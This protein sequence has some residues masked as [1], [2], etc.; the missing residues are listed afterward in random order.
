MHHSIE[1]WFAI[2]PFRYRADTTLNNN[3]GTI[4]LSIFCEL[5]LHP[6]YAGR[7]VPSVECR[8]INQNRRLAEL[9]KS[10]PKFFI[11]KK[12]CAVVL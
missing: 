7:H 9:F 6:I 10:V 4:K 12:P 5:R 2:F 1:Q 11:F 8:L 3:K